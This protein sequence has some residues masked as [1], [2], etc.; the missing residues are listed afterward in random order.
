MLEINSAFGFIP[1]RVMDRYKT[2]F[3]TQDG[4]FQWTCL[5]FGLE[6]PPAIFQRILTNIIRRHNVKEFT[7]NYIDDILIFSKLFAEHI[8]HLSKVLTAIKKEE[9]RLKYAKCTFAA[10]QVK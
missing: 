4:K 5:P 3:I 2:A 7:A 8:G 9:F 6:T 10:K 1:L